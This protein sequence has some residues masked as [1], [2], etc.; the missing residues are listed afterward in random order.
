MGPGLKWE[1]QDVS[2]RLEPLGMFFSYCIFLTILENLL[3]V[4][5]LQMMTSRVAGRE[6]HQNG[7]GSS[8]EAQDMLRCNMSRAARWCQYVIFFC[9]FFYNLS[10]LCLF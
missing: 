10:L 4:L 2:A 8:S 3:K 1:A 6:M 5:C 7:N 9:C